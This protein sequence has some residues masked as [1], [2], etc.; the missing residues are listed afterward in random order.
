MYDISGGGGMENRPVKQY[1]ESVEMGWINTDNV[2]T[3]VNYCTYVRN[4]R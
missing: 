3:F 4:V 1:Q 2:R